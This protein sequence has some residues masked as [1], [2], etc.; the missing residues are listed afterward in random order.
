MDAVHDVKRFEE[1][2][3]G[4]LRLKISMSLTEGPYLTPLR[5]FTETGMDKTGVTPDITNLPQ[6][7]KDEMGHNI[8]T[9]TNLIADSGFFEDAYS[10]EKIKSLFTYHLQPVVKKIIKNPF[11]RLMNMEEDPN[12]YLLLPTADSN[13]HEIKLMKEDILCLKKERVERQVPEDKLVTA[14][15]ELKHDAISMYFDRE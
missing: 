11:Y 7:I 13:S 5:N 6:K 14:I 12:H 15:S 2:S 3:L 1:P 9:I 8:L 10:T 4:Q